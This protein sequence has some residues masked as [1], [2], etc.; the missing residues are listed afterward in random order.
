M[1]SVVKEVLL[2]SMILSLAAPAYALTTGQADVKAKVNAKL[3][4]AITMESNASTDFLSGADLAEGTEISYPNGLKVATVEV[5][6]N[7]KNGFK[8]TFSSENDGKLTLLDDLGAY[9]TSPATEEQTAYTVDLEQ[10]TSG[11]YGA[12]LPVGHENIVWSTLSPQAELEFVPNLTG[13]KIT[14]S[15]QYDLEINVPANDNLYAGDYRDIITIQI[16][17]V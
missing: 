15:A 7:K 8:L 2:A 10:G 1:K 13:A 3:S 14:K 11:I 6:C 4:I 9:V 17:D 5:D 12:Q 16:S